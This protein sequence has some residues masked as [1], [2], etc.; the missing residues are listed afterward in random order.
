MTPQILIISANSRVKRL[1][2]QFLSPEQ[3][4]LLVMSDVADGLVFLAMGNVAALLIDTSLPDFD[5][6]MLLSLL[7]KK[8]SWK[9]LPL[10]AVGFANIRHVFPK[11]TRFAQTPEQAVSILKEILATV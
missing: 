4:D 6:A 9:T 1:Y 11:H 2:H 3:C 7:K 10:L 8:S 5:I